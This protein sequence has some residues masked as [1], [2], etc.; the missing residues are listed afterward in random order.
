[1]C[2]IS[3]GTPNG[4]KRIPLSVRPSEDVFA[5][6]VGLDPEYGLQL[7]GESVLLEQDADIFW[8]M[9]KTLVDAPTDFKLGDNN[10]NNNN[11]NEENEDEGGNYENDDFEAI[12]G[13][14]LPKSRDDEQQQKIKTSDRD[15]IRQLGAISQ[16]LK[17]KGGDLLFLL[18]QEIDLNG[19]RLGAEGLSGDGVERFNHPVR[20]RVEAKLLLTATATKREEGEEVDVEKEETLEESEGETKKCVKSKVIG[21][22]TS[23]RISVLG[24]ESSFGSFIH[25]SFA[26]ENVDMMLLERQHQQPQQEQDKDLSLLSAIAK[27]GSVRGFGESFIPF[28]LS[29]S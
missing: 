27:L 13:E 17:S 23:S 7:C 20:G 28:P 18:R 19:K 24:S 6:E 15:K 25:T 9:L 4:S 21:D 16:N 8:G 2:H 11:N 26:R 12:D 29:V 3:F 22:V 14:E 5:T 10:H 1:M